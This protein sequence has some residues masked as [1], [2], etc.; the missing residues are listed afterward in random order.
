MGNF[1]EVERLQAGIREWLLRTA[2]NGRHE[3]RSIPAPAVLALLCAATFGPELADAADLDSA[4]AVARTGVLSSVGASVLGDVLA[5]ALDRARSAHPGGDLSR[6]DL[7]RE[8]S[9]S[10]KEILAGPGERAEAVRSDIAMV[11]REIDAGG[12]VFLA[13]IEAGDEDLQ[14]EVLTAV[15]AVSTEFGEME[16]LLADLTRAAGE[17]QDSLADQG[18]ELRVT[19]DRVGR[20]SAD[21]RM[22]R[23][24][25]AVIERRTRGWV[26]GSADRE[27]A[28]PRWAGGC[29]Y[30]GLLPY[31]QAHA[32]VFYGRDRLTAQLAGLLAHGGLVM[33][34]GASGAG[35]TSLLQAG[36]VPA[37][38]RGV[39]VPG[40]QS[41][42]RVSMT[43]ASRPLT[44]L[45][46]RLAQLSGGDPAVTRKSLA[47][48]PGDAHLLVGEIV[49]TA[50]GG[51]PGRAGGPAE[52]SRLVLIIDQFEQVFAAAGEEAEQER[53]AFIDAVCAAATR[54]TGPRN[55]P[56]ALV[57]IAVRGDYWDRCASC[58]QLVPAMQRDQLVV[59]PLAEADLR[60]VITGPAEASGL[61]MEDGL[62][63]TI[64]ADLRSAREDGQS[65]PGA[66]AGILP[67]L[68]QAML[69]TWEHRQGDQLTKL[70]YEGTGERAGVARSVE[71]SAEAAYRAL[72]P[73]Q[74]AVARDVL[75][76][77]TALG[78]DGRSA[79]RAV[80]R[81][82]LHVGLPES[83][84]GQSPA[85]RLRHRR[86]IAYPPAVG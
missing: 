80:T 7:Q 5:A 75:R 12:T 76:R 59:G 22:I 77:M 10:L 40:S 49:R 83:L 78:P 54:P 39:Q 62:A 72:A 21:V 70:G 36:L 42:P 82:D 45:A 46:A 84:P 20:Q 28:R 19:S 74:Q 16:F 81:A 58:P 41:W 35:K 38:A 18:A 27:Q 68:S 25:L 67:L 51:Q 31:D 71:V 69:L 30:R 4:V 73:D 63:D 6:A 3:L 8:I 33:V 47:E 37:L 9:R 52:A 85:G 79:C 55:E 14:R 34:T 86:R 11:L 13:A 53:A 60:R 50:A 26:P 32:A 44:E 15:E 48:A 64:L 43:P 29:P 65:G 57:V 1:E 66:G 56:A 24:E 61:Q 23:E 17:V 2:R